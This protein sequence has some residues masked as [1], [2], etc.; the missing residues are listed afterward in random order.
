M[1]I[2]TAS[3]NTTWEINKEKQEEYIRILVENLPELRADIGIS[4]TELASIMGL[5]RQT[6]SAIETGTRA[7][8]WATY[9]S[10]ILFFDC[11]EITHKTIRDRG[12]YPH[13]L[14]VAFN[15]GKKHTVPKWLS[16]VPDEIIE[17]LD[18]E[19]YQY[20]R[21]VLMLEYAR[22]AK[23]PGRTVAEKFETFNPKNT[24]SE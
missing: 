3:E 22:C 10:L 23:I 18:Y 1:G 5:A 12:I 7:M 13:D 24:D 4:Q 8:S 15:G 2:I 17:K 9:L 21:T 20:I 16:E 11:N 6:V 14:I 19:A